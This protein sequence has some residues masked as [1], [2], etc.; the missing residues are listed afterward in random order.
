MREWR[1]PNKFDKAVRATVSSGYQIDASIIWVHV[2]DQTLS[3]VRMVAD[4]FALNVS[5]STA[6]VLSPISSKIHH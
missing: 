1:W 6:L 5:L 2:A 3:R 4:A